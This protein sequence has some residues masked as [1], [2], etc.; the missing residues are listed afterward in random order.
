MAYSA[1]V[2]PMRRMLGGVLREM[3]GGQDLG[4]RRSEDLGD[5]LEQADVEVLVGVAEREHHRRPGAQV[6]DLLGVGLGEDQQRL[7]VPPE[8]DRDDV[9]A[10]HPGGR[11]TARR[12]ARARGTARCVRR[13]GCAAVPCP[14]DGRRP[15]AGT[16]DHGHVRHG[17][18]SVATGG[19]PAVAG[20]S[21]A[22]HRRA[23][24]R[25]RRAGRRGR[26]CPAVPPVPPSTG[27]CR[28]P[29]IEPRAGIPCAGRA[30]RP[31][32]WPSGVSMSM[33]WGRNAASIGSSDAMSIPDPLDSRCDRVRAQRLAELLGI[34]RFVGAGRRPTNRPGRR[35][36]ASRSL[37]MRPSRP[38]SLP[39]SPA[40]RPVRAA[41]RGRSA[42]APD[43][44]CPAGSARIGHGHPSRVAPSGGSSRRGRAVS[45]GHDH[46][47]SRLSSRRPVRSRWIGR[48]G[49]AAVD[50]GVEVG[51]R[52]GQPRRRRAADPEVGDAARVEPLDE[53]VL[54][55]ALAEAGDLDPLAL[56]DRRPPGR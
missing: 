42:P 29:R 53:L 25:A 54:V 7:A 40:A 38:P 11:W 19:R 24:R 8:P 14:Q 3:G 15:S 21:G 5:A 13:R 28:P 51:P 1:G 55:D 18:L 39:G 32:S 49:D 12:S 2:R 16:T 34:D 45:S 10:C 46:V 26:G 47:R 30:R 4:R 41:R 44:A 50:H 23:C 35:G 36:R 33:I 17:R 22:C 9:R 31:A 56:L 37:P 52:H 43:V 27:R 6:A 48:D 20:V